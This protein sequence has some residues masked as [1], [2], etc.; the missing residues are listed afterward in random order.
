MKSKEVN[1][2]RSV[3]KILEYLELL[4]FYWFLKVALIELHSKQYAFLFSKSSF[5]KSSLNV[6]LLEDQ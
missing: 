1:F 4:Y 2:N 5:N 6:R 3:K